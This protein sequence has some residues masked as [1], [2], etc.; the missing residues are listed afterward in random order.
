MTDFVPI[1]PGQNSLGSKWLHVPSGLTVTLS[2]ERCFPGL[3]WEAIHAPMYEWA[4][5]RL[6]PAEPGT[7]CCR[8]LD[9]G[10]GSGY[11][12]AMLARDHVVTGVDASREAIDFCLATQPVDA[13]T[14]VFQRRTMPDLSGLGRFDA[15]VAIESIEH[16][17]E[18]AATIRAF[19]ELVDVGAKL[20]ITTPEA[21]PSRTMS[22]WHVREYTADELR[23]LLFENGFDEFP[24]FTVDHRFPGTLMVEAVAV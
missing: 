2:R 21:D 10:C 12:T 13:P 22:E 7:R 14:F 3:R 15:I 16:V 18:D 8:V 6:G 5:Q 20:F 17:E 11:G 23:A 24:L 9:A 1:I 19:R 4:R